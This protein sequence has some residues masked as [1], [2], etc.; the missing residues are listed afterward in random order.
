MTMKNIELKKILRGARIYV[1]RGWC[2]G[3]VALDRNGRV[4][5]DPCHRDAACWCATGA[6]SRAI[7]KLFGWHET[8]DFT[9][10]DFTR[11]ESKSQRWLVIGILATNQR[12]HID[13]EFGVS[14]WNDDDATTQEHVLNAFD[15]SIALVGSEVVVL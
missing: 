9:A 1:E 11:L 15:K 3:E 14:E 6:I 2:Q 8:E 4:L 5:D 7:S 12:V 13:D 10:D